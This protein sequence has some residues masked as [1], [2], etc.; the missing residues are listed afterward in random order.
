MV[1]VISSV[2]A[3]LYSGLFEGLVTFS[4]EHEW[5]DL[6][7]GV[8]GRSYLKICVVGVVGLWLGMIR[9]HIW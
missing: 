1:I 5:F 6:E 7:R 2:K 3:K 4:F 8:D 9:S